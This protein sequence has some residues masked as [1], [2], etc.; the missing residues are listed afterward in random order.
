MNL[1]IRLAGMVSYLD[2]RFNAHQHLLREKV[3]VER[4]LCYVVGDSEQVGDGEEFLPENAQGW[5][6]PVLAK[7]KANESTTGY[8]TNRFAGYRPK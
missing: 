6:Y 8:G 4:V 7:E 1:S 5:T 3:L 2:C